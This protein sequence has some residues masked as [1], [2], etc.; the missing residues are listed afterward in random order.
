MGEGIRIFE[1]RE[2][3]VFGADYGARAFEFEGGRGRAS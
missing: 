3:A 1:R 2:L